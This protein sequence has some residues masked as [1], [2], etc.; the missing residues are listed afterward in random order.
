MGIIRFISK[1]EILLSIIGFHRFAFV[2]DLE[3]NWGEPTP[4][5]QKQFHLSSNTSFSSAFLNLSFLCHDGPEDK[6]TVTIAALIKFIF[7]I[8]HVAFIFIAP[9]WSLLCRVLNENVCLNEGC[10]HTHTLGFQTPELR[11]KISE[12][13]LVS[14]QGIRKMLN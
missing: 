11:I 12:R 7:I 6:D 9:A 8:F 3:L 4:N 14:F 5:P 2:E 13:T 10:A 1:D